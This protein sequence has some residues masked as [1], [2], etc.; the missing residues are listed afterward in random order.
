LLNL[1]P[2]RT[3]L[4]PAYH[5]P[6]KRDRSVDSTLD[7]KP[8]IAWDGEGINLRGPGKPQ[9][10]VLFGSS[11]GC[12]IDPDGLSTF[13][14]LD[15]IIATGVAN[16]K[17]IHVGFAFGYDSNMIIQSLSPTSLARLHQHGWVRIKRSSTGET[18]VIT[19]AKSKYFRVTKQSANYDRKK[20]P[21][22]KVTVQ[23]FDI[24]SF[25]NT[26]FIRA[27]ESNVG[28]VPDIITTGKAGRSNFTIDEL[29]SVYKYWSVEIQLLK[30]LADAL[31]K[32]VY[33]ADLRITQWYGPGAL[34]SFALNK[35]SIQSHMGSSSP[36]IRQASRYAYAGGRFELFKCGR[37]VGRIFSIDINSAYPF[38]ISQLPSFQDG[39]W[40]HVENPAKLAKFAVY[41]VKLATQKGFSRI[42]SPLFHRDKEH[43]IT[44]PWLVDGWYWGP[45][46]F[47][48][49]RY[50]A[51]ILEGYEYLHST[52][53]PFSWVPDMYATRRDWKARGISAELALKLCLNSIY[54]KLAQRIGWDE[55]KKRI[56]PFH[57]LEWAG[58]V[59]SNTRAMLFNV[60]CQIPFDKLIAVETDG[61]YTTMN[62]TD[63]N[64]QH[65]TTLGGWEIKEFSEVMYIQSGLAWLKDTDGKWTEKRRGLDG[66]KL[67]HHPEDCDCPS[68]FHLNACRDYL[69]S[70][71]PKPDRYHPWPVHQGQTTRFVGLGQAL[72]SSI[73][74]QERHCVWETV[75]RE[76]SPGQS[77]KRIHM[78]HFCDACRQGL[79]AYDAAHD[80]VI[81][82]MS[83]LDPR[84]HQHSIPWEPEDGHARWRDYSELQSDDVTLQYV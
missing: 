54:G 82:S 3:E 9:S 67:N 83:V 80:L 60:M 53:R 50:G 11:E 63:L 26:S 39:E 68:V 18:Y 28:P 79:S 33:N 58:W 2:T 20:N 1:T 73:M 36:E 65:S 19:Y 25:F 61:L 77:G 69:K 42:P 38:G 51:T 52:I 27:Y 44:F 43:N 34:A 84:S 30:Q 64:I 76:I 48:A 23:I 47:Q 6:H 78:H 4:P 37:T 40:V 70:L 56:P 12:I 66:C 71:H 13:E 22:A 21:H 35:H 62:P 17:A 59:T 41:H 24:F 7:R 10:Y 14:C 8:F 72:A 49:Q 32:R 81:H 74:T 57:Q 55:V 75:P 45:E 46:A 5:T 15:H 29:D 31:R 16:P